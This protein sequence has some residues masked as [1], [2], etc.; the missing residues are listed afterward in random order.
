MINYIL[1]YFFRQN[2]TS[3]YNYRDH[4]DLHSS[5]PLPLFHVLLGYVEY[6]C[7]QCLFPECIIHK[8]KKKK[9]PFCRKNFKIE[10]ENGRKRQN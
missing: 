6:I 7:Y 4:N 3:S 8:M 10:Y 5:L 1:N 2:K 9:R